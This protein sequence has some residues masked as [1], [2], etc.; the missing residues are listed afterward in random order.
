MPS[1]FA[2]FTGAGSKKNNPYINAYHPSHAPLPKQHT[3][4]TTT[5]SQPLPAVSPRGSHDFLAE[6]RS[7]AN[8]DPIT[9]RQLPEPNASVPSARQSS[10]PKMLQSKKSRKKLGQQDEGLEGRGTANEEMS[11]YLNRASR[12]QQTTGKRYDLFSA[13]ERERMEREEAIRIQRAGEFY[14]PER[15]VEE[16]YNERVQY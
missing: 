5:T 15:R 3:T 11:A 6:A 1:L 13:A 7:L 14:A 12:T 2:R 4:T 16:F 9:G 8:R 10:M